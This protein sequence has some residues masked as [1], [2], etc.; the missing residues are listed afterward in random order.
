MIYYRLLSGKTREIENNQFQQEP[1]PVFVYYTS[2]PSQGLE[3]NKQELIKVLIVVNNI[4]CI[5]NIYGS[6]LNSNI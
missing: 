2:L 3:L 1:L 4:L 6:I 5:D